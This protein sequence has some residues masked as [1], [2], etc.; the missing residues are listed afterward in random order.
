M[1]IDHL[2]ARNERVDRPITDHNDVEAL[3]IEPCSGDQRRRH[4]AE[5]RFGFRIAQD[6]LR[7]H[8]LG[9]ESGGQDG[10]LK[11]PEQS[12]QLHP[13]RA[14]DERHVKRRPFSTRKIILSRQMCVATSR[15]A[16]CPPV[17]AQLRCWVQFREEQAFPQ[18]VRKRVRNS[19]FGSA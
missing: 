7:Q 1:D 9:N 12:H 15:H 5:Q 11:F 13:L 18:P 3:W 10:R 16:G 17:P 8:R 4:V 14:E 2:P 6:R 19:P